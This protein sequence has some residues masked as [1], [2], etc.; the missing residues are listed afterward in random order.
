MSRCWIQGALTKT[1]PV[2]RLDAV[3]TSGFAPEA[4]TKDASGLGATCLRRIPSFLNPHRGTS[5][6]SWVTPGGPQ[7]EATKN[8]VI[9]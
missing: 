5:G 7:I 8:L 4:R 6:L 9:S 3:P 2:T 1:D